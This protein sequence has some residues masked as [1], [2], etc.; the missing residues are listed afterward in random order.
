MAPQRRREVGL[1]GHI[2]FTRQ[3]VQGNVSLAQGP[4]VQASGWSMGSVVGKERIVRNK[5][6]IRKVLEGQKA[7]TQFKIN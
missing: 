5:D 3:T 6:H 4:W 2:G 1:K 7:R